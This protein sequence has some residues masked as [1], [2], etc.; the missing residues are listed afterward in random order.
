MGIYRI[1]GFLE[2]VEPAIKNIPTYLLFL[3]CQQI[4]DIFSILFSLLAPRAAGT[5]PLAIC[6]LYNNGCDCLLVVVVTL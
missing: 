4:Q 2:K 3:Y 1:P 6:V 5:S